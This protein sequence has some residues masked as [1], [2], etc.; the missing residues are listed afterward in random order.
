[1]TNHR[2]CRFPTPLPRRLGIHV[3]AVRLLLAVGLW[4]ALA[5]LGRCLVVLVGRLL[6]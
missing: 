4:V 5:F 2:P 3:E 1:M 6:P